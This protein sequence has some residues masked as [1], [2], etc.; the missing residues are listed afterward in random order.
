[1]E[2]DIDNYLASATISSDNK[3]TALEKR[4]L[5]EP[6]VVQGKTG[7]AKKLAQTFIMEVEEG[8]E[9]DELLAKLKNDPSIFYA[10]YDRVNKR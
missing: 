7:A 3:L 4:K 8:Q 5:V 1:M 6:I 9:A 10:E 2:K